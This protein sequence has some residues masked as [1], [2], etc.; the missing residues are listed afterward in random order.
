MTL[1]ESPLTPIAA[2]LAV[3]VAVT[4]LAQ[5]HAVAFPQEREDYAAPVPFVPMTSVG[6][7][8]QMLLRSGEGFRAGLPNYD[9]VIAFA[10]EH[11][12]WHRPFPY[13]P[14]LYWFAAPLSFLGDTVAL[15][16]W[17]LLFLIGFP[18]V[19]VGYLRAGCS[20]LERHQA[21][22]ALL[23]LMTFALSAATLFQ[24]ERGNFD[25][26]VVLVYLASLWLSARHQD[27][28]A[29]AL[30]GTAV[31]LKVYPLVLV[32]FLFLGRRW[33]MLAGMAVALGV[34][35]LVTGPINNAMWL[36]ALAADRVSMFDVAAVNTSMAN[37]VGW[38]LPHLGRPASRQLGLILSAIAGGAVVW[39]YNRSRQAQK[40]L[41]VAEI[42]VW[43]LPLMFL[44]PGIS[45]AYTLFALVPLLFGLAMVWQR[46]P[47][48]RPTALVAS[49]FV[50]I[51]QSPIVSCLRASAFGS[52]LPIF[53]LGL[54][55]LVICVY[56][57]VAAGVVPTAGVAARVVTHDVA[58]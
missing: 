7:D 19:L 21:G 51:C 58:K 23:T 54:V 45:W 36:R 48:L 10:R 28:A 8:L 4:L 29:G 44:V 37:L 20:R 5:A 31:L 25:W 1:P 55:A 33:H 40:D 56:R 41:P 53:S 38:M 49:L 43:G 14:L 50:G 27:L 32:P 6:A 11:D 13:A 57:F 47:S 17:S 52:R 3:T 39:G 35:I 24:L 26:L 9:A 42:G 34:L 18:L 16:V 46:T 12:Q 2:A 15:A 30:L 22:A